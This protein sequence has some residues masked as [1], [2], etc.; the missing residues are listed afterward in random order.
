MSSKSY[1]TR[2]S[3]RLPDT[4]NFEVLRGGKSGQ[5]VNTEQ[6]EF[7]KGADPEPRGE[8]RRR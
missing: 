5:I 3:R 1:G 7:L 4:Y 2:K 6:F 8:K